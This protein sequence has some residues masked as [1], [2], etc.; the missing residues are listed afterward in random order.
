MLTD[1]LGYF[2]A[3]IQISDV[4]WTSTVEYFT[5][6]PAKI[7]TLMD[8]STLEHIFVPPRLRSSLDH[9][10]LGTKAQFTDNTTISLFGK[11]AFDPD[12]VSND[13]PMPGTPVHMIDSSG[14]LHTTEADN[15]GIFSF[16]VDKGT[17]VSV[18]I[19]SYKNYRWLS[20]IISQTTKETQ[21]R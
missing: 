1:K 16:A 11:V 19:P 14:T 20:N 8:G 9:L 15:N 18:F 6:T 7:D 3:D 13:C 10:A 17:E 21:R 4:S 2:S 5:V 12:I